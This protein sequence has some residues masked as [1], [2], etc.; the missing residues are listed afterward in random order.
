MKW[1]KENRVVIK[2]WFWAIIGV[3][4]V[5]IIVSIIINFLS[6]GIPTS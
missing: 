1:I 6:F 2:E 3:I 4:I 5:F